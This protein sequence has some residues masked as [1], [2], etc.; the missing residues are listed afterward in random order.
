MISIEP[1]KKDMGYNPDKETKLK[2]REKQLVAGGSLNRRQKRATEE[3]QYA[4]PA[5]IIMKS[6]IE[7]EDPSI[8]ALAIVI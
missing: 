5:N 7:L 6:S 2:I 3:P 8:L 1:E 4:I